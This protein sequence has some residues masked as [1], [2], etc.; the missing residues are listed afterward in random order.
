MKNNCIISLPYLLFLLLCLSTNGLMAQSWERVLT[1]NHQSNSK[2]GYVDVN[3]DYLVDYRQDDINPRQFIRLNDLGELVTIYPPLMDSLST[4]HPVY[5]SAR[6]ADGNFITARNFFTVEDQDTFRMFKYDLSGNTIWMHEFPYSGYDISVNNLTQSSDGAYLVVGWRGFNGLDHLQLHKSDEAGSVL[7]EATMPLNGTYGF[8]TDVVELADQSYLTLT[9]LTD[10]SFIANRYFMAKVS[11]S[12]NV[13]WSQYRDQLNPRVVDETILAD[14]SFAILERLGNGLEVRL[15]KFDS[16]GQE[17]WSQSWD[18]ANVGFP[19]QLL[20][21]ADGGYAVA[22][23]IDSDDPNATE[24]NRIG[25]MRL[26][27]NGN[28]LWQNSYA[29]AIYHRVEDIKEAPDGGFVLFGGAGLDVEDSNVYVIKTDSEGVS[30]TNLIEGYVHYDLN[31][32]CINEAGE[33]AL[34]NWLVKAEGTQGT[35]YSSVNSAGYY[36]IAVDTGSYTVNNVIPNAY[37]DA[38][39]IDSIVQQTMPNDTIRVDL[40]VQSIEQCPLMEIYT[41]TGPFRICDTSVIYVSVC[42]QGT[43]LAEDATVEMTL[44]SELTY[45]GA[46]VP[47]L[48]QNGDAYVFDLGDMNYLECVTFLVYA[49]APCDVELLGQS[50]CIESHVFPDTSCFPQDSLWNGASIAAFANCE[51]ND[52]R[53]TLKNVGLG[54]MLESLEYIVVE[55]DVIMMNEPYTLPSGDSIEFIHPANGTFY[56]ISSPQVLG[57]PGN[58]MPTAFVEACGEGENGEVSLGFV[59][60]FSLDDADFFIDIICEEIVGAYDPNDK[61]AEPRGYGDPHYIDANTDIEYKIRFQNT[62]TDTAHRVVVRDPLSALLDPSTIR[63]GAS[64]HPYTFN[65]TGS[66]LMVFTF[67][68]IMLPDSNVNFAASQ[69]FVQFT[70]SQQADLPVGS[71]I[72]NEAAIYFDF[73]PP[74]I[75]NQTYHTIG[76]DFIEVNTGRV[77]RPDLEVRVYPNPFSTQTTIE[78]LG[79]PQERL[80]FKLFDTAGRLLRQ[81]HFTDNRY[82]LSAAG[83]S[84]GLYFYTIRDQ[85]GIVNTGRVIVH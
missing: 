45:T 4:I 46:T 32:N 30:I 81:D 27:G 48:S 55:D 64:S 43:I 72:L 10:S 1:D 58:S 24:D 50:I 2:Y 3:G 12:G 20:A 66:G 44:D 47:L 70:I 25:L 82:E 51:G 61:Q 37:W 56:L 78:I 74:I 85:N 73:N 14:G 21:T 6:A 13:V 77:L 80:D 79:G 67:E 75:T 5:L 54:D 7:W 9:N 29:A 33:D 36:A 71:Q 52:V 26:D 16:N 17:L 28:T 49:V 63:L 60:Q 11:A 62:G 38:C 83:L 41:N 23:V 34:E 19:Y 69:G 59:N 22:S 31:E 18:I 35:F 15:V 76:E 42:N 40:P 84:V 65:L 53:L 57:H 8:Y 68:D 39:V